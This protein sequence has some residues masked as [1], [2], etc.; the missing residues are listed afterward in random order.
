MPLSY[1]KEGRQEGFCFG[2]AAS[3]CCKQFRLGR[4]GRQGHYNAR[5]PKLLHAVQAKG[6]HHV[7]D[8]EASEKSQRR[9]SCCGGACVD[10]SERLLFGEPC[11]LSS[12]HLELLEG[13]ACDRVACVCGVRCAVGVVLALT[14]TRA[15]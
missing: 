14:R 9:R 12:E 15:S 10:A 2:D 1:F 6:E 3:V 13:H 11:A 5:K 8:G 4:A 7:G